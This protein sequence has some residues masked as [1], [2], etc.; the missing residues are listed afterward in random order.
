MQATSDIFLGWLRL[1]GADGR[2]LSTNFYWLP[3][4][5]STFDWAVEHQKDHPYYTA[6]TKYEDLSELNRLPKVRLDAAAT[7]L[8]LEGAAHQR[9]TLDG[10]DLSK[11]TR[12]L[13]FTNGATPAAVKVRT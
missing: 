8:R 3:K 4:T 12:T 2:P 11:A 13:A 6:V 9:I 7:F 5:L 1:T 10:G